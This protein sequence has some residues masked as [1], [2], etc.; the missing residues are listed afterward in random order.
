MN[1]EQLT[2]DLREPIATLDHY[3]KMLATAPESV[4]CASDVFELVEQPLTR[5]QLLKA[6]DFHAGRIAEMV[7]R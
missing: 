2:V 3:R 5:G 7:R 1:I 6:I 4:P